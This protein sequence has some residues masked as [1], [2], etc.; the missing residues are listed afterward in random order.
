MGCENVMIKVGEW[1][2]ITLLV[3]G[4][5]NSRQYSHLATCVQDKILVS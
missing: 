4:K 2:V 1:E 3:I 5:H